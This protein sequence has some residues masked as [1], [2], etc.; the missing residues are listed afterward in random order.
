MRKIIELKLF[1][2]LIYMVLHRHL[3]TDIISAIFSAQRSEDTWQTILQ[4]MARWR[5][6]YRALNHVSLSDRWPERLHGR[7]ALKVSW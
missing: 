7:L 5:S 3:N 1:K 2:M 4:Q 6:Q